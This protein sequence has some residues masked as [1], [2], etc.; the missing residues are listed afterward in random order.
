LEN[1]PRIEFRTTV[2]PPLPP[3]SYET[4]TLNHPAVSKPPSP[5]EMP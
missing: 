2:C 5:A 3:G 4:I 1:Q